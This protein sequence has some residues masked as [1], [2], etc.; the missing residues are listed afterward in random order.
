MTDARTFEA[1]FREVFTREHPSL[2]RYL[3][4]LT[5]DAAL[6]A[7]AAQD[8]FIRLHERGA[9]PEEPR[10]WLVAVAHNRIRDDRRAEAR[11]LRLHGTAGDLPAADPAPAPDI[12]LEMDERRRAV[13]VVL[14]AM[15]AR[16]RRLLLLRHEGYSYRELAAALG[17]SEA[18]VGALLARAHS[19]FARR[20]TG[21]R[22]APETP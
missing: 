16:D 5:G 22:R 21:G 10:S 7:D 15:S 20:Y 6:A 8:A 17:V 14:D 11:H 13:R 12:A 2:V 4:R 1:N 19:R 3:A 18:S 9:M